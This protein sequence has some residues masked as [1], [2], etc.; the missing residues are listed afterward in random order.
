MI[1]LIEYNST[2]WFNI[3]EIIRKHYNYYSRRAKRSGKKKIFN[4]EGNNFETENN[5]LVN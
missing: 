3:L 2:K 4:I 5:E 1:K